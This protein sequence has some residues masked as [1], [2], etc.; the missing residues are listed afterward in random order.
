MG[1]A[2]S[3]DGH[4]NNNHRSAGRG[5]P[6]PEAQLQLRF[7]QEIA[8]RAPRHPLRAPLR[9]TLNAASP[10]PQESFD[11]LDSPRRDASADLTVALAGPVSLP[12][13]CV[14]VWAARTPT[15]ER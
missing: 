7:Q 13:R 8:A 5:V 15:A 6:S 4:T 9:I 10:L 11:A 12:K 2:A 14:D 3:A 1:C